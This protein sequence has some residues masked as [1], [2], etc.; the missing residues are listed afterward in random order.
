MACNRTLGFRLR[1]PAERCGLSLHLQP[2]L[3]GRSI[4]SFRSI[5]TPVGQQR[6][7]LGLVTHLSV[8]LTW[9][10]IFVIALHYSAS[11]RRVIVTRQGA[12]A[13]AAVYGPMIWLIMSLA[14]IH[15]ATGKSPAFNARWWIQV[16]AHIP[17][18]AIPLVFTA[19]RFLISAERS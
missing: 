17:F 13:V 4:R 11:L 6:V 12:L 2:A 14:V 16:F 8:A 1:D 5:R 9:S 19:R 7:A 10:A 18:V 15:L 3:A